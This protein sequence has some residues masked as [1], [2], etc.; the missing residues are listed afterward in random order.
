MAILSGSD[1]WIKAKDQ[2][3]EYGKSVKAAK[4][5]LL[6]FDQVNKLNAQA[7]TK[8]ESE[9]LVNENQIN[10][11]KEVF[12]GLKKILEPIFNIMTSSIADS[13]ELLKEIGPLLQPL[14][15]LVSTVLVPIG[16]IFSKA[17]RAVTKLVSPIVN[18]LVPAIT[19]IF[20]IVSE[21]VDVLFTTLEPALDEIFIF[22]GTIGEAI[23]SCLEAIWAMISPIVD[24][25]KPVLSLILEAALQPMVTAI[26]LIM[27]RM[28]GLFKIV[29]LVADLFVAI[30]KSVW[31]I[32]NADWGSLGDIW[33][34]FG[35]KAKKI[36]S[37]ISASW[38]RLVQ[39]I[40]E[41][42]SNIWKK[43]ANFFI[44]IARGIV[45]WINNIIIALL[46]KISDKFGWN[47][48]I[49]PINPPNLLAKGGVIKSPTNAILGEYAGA[50]TNPEIAAP[51]SMIAEIVNEGSESTNNIL[52]QLGRQII[53]AID[54]KD[55]E[56]TIGDD[57]IASSAA[58]GNRAFY[59]RTGK[60]LIGV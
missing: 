25:L 39:K 60:E 29:K 26:T 5:E 1:S 14:F 54:N 19:K 38:D 44:N 15:D 2:V 3:D 52:I 12:V 32:V 8:F 23:G 22:L 41:A 58:R 28:D 35:E 49:Q 6:G 10:L 33:K 53:T 16:T 55:L 30:W 4:R 7:E 21:L 45:N 50:N 46:N 47:W 20:D 59:N 9:D 40:G 17:S 13:V 51:R 34:N 56:V 27:N 48:N 57:V 18:K 42:A 43:F 36:F 37:D 24:V 11:F 31:A